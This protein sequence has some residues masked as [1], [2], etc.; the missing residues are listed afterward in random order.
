MTV[1]VAMLAPL[2]STPSAAATNVPTNST[3]PT[4]RATALPWFVRFLP[5]LRA[6]FHRQKGDGAGERSEGR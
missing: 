4:T 1:T 6:G 2:S 3:S 5:A